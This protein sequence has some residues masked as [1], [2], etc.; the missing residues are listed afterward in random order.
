MAL[1]INQVYQDIAD[2]LINKYQT[3]LGHIDTSQILFLEEDEK[4][5]KKYADIQIVKSPY[6]FLTN[7]KF[8]MTIYSPKTIG[9][10]DAQLHVLIM[11]ELFHIDENFEKLVKHDCEDF[12]VILSTY[13]I[14]WDTNPNTPDPL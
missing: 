6:T 4:A 11:H 14:D 8:I 3:T 12:S 2:Q 10:T 5:P 1:K 7:Y 13:G 9:M